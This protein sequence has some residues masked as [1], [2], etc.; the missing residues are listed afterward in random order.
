MPGSFLYRTNSEKYRYIND[1][2]FNALIV[3]DIVA[4]HKIRG[5]AFLG[6]LVDF[7]MDKVG[8]MTSIRNIFNEFTFHR[9]VDLLLTIKDAYPKL[10]LVR[11]LHKP[12]YTRAFE[13]LILLM[14]FCKK[15]MNVFNPFFIYLEVV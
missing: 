6:K 2:V 10:L 12:F 4:K 3:R 14:S 7:L 1:G 8:N 5:K 9:E 15:E 11:I 13:L